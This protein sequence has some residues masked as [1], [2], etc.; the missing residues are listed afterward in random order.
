MFFFTK[1]RAL[2]AY[3]AL[4]ADCILWLVGFS[5]VAAGCSDPKC[6]ET[7]IKIGDRCEGRIESSEETDA[8]RPARTQVAP[9]P[10]RRLI[11]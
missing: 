10:M 2:L 6:G 4:R 11:A 7:K 3:S 8:R 1:L 9:R 5:V